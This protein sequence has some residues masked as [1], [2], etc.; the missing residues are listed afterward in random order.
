MRWHE[1]QFDAGQGQS[2]RDLITADRGDARQRQHIGAVLPSHRED[3]LVQCP[4]VLG[5]QPD[6]PDTGCQAA[7]LHPPKVIKHAMGAR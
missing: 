5:Q 2:L 1:L 6:N 7:P 4:H 3:C